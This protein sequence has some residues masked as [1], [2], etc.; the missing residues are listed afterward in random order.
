MK[1]LSTQ[2]LQTM[3]YD[4]IMSLIHHMKSLEISEA[5]TH[6]STLLS[7][8]FVRDVLNQH[9]QSSLL[10]DINY[11][12][13]MEELKI[14]LELYE[15]ENYSGAESLFESAIARI[16]RANQYVVSPENQAR[17][18]EA[19]VELLSHAMGVLACDIE[20][21]LEHEGYNGMERFE[22]YKTRL[23]V[24]FAPIKLEFDELLQ[25]STQAHKKYFTKEIMLQYR[26]NANR[27]I[28]K[29]ETNDYSQL[30][31]SSKRSN[32]AYQ[33]HGFHKKSKYNPKTAIEAETVNSY[34]STL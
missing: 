23:Y 29:L 11:D 25:S 17:C 33:T 22:L 20:G 15:E 28:K 4:E 19:I 2:T 3:T 31:T 8:H 9:D 24:E 26:T 12:C 5:Y 30:K 14:G 34:D 7:C 18:M 21:I 10:A 6:Y 16:K 32:E 1:K 13:A 27:L